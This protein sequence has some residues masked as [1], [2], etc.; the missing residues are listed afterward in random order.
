MDRKRDGR[1]RFGPFLEGIFSCIDREEHDSGDMR[2]QTEPM[3]S[4]KEND[5]K[6]ERPGSRYQKREHKRHRT[7]QTLQTLQTSN[8]KTLQIFYDKY[9]LAD[10]NLERYRFIAF[11]IG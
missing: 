9:D 6:S 7:L 3:S 5:E 1:A 2:C 8:F 4:R 11:E 10:Y